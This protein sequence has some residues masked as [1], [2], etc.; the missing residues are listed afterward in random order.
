MK[1]K[2]LAIG[3]ILL[4]VGTCIIPAI[5][6]DTKKSL[7]SSRGNWLYV[8]G[9][10]P[11]N[12]TKI[13]DAIDNA[14][15]LDTIFVYHGIY[16]E[17]ISSYTYLLTIIGENKNNTVIDGQN[18][19]T[20][21][22]SFMRGDSSFSGFS[23]IHNGMG[24]N[25]FGIHISQDNVIENNIIYGGI[26]IDGDLNR[27]RNNIIKKSNHHGIFM[28]FASSFNNISEN[29][30][31]ENNGAGI[32]V[33]GRINEIV[34]N[35][36]YNNTQEGIRMTDNSNFVKINYNVIKNNLGY[37]IYSQGNGD[38][39]KM[40]SI[41]NNDAGLYLDFSHFNIISQ[42]NFIKN[43]KFQI[44]YL[45]N[46]LFPKSNTFKQNYYD[47]AGFFIKIISGNVRM[48][49]TTHDI[50]GDIVYYYRPSLT[51]DWT[52]VKEPYDTPRMS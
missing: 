28:D 8:G 22:V 1:R 16:Y 10:G 48:Y 46:Y 19:T 52:P 15:Q 32:W 7:P 24:T 25:D 51:V 40:N 47:D 4:F 33:D 38:I 31:E 12:F 30:I 11:G 2:C 3:I 39:I 34:R 9:S 43:S 14:S 6:Q 23:I 44:S 29:I 18:K 35:Y 5:A 21:V 49:F 45:V 36:I 13:Q 20:D 50:F 37:G 42:N 41:E 26:F 27:V 17:H